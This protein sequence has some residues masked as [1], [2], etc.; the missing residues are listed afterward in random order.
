MSF[1]FQ[2]DVS[3]WDMEIEM[4][5]FHFQEPIINVE[6]DKPSTS[7]GPSTT[8]ASHPVNPIGIA[9]PL[10][11]ASAA[12][13]FHTTKTST[14]VSGN[15]NPGSNVATPVLSIIQMS[16][17]HFTDTFRKSDQK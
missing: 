2:E 13:G 5:M 6:D 11:A 15:G 4:G 17:D 9:N 3:K 8:T 10:S 12:A 1:F 16:E 14:A 7:S